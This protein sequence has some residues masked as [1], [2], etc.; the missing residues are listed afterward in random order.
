MAILYMRVGI[1]DESDP[2]VIKEL[3]ESAVPVKIDIYKREENKLGDKLKFLEVRGIYC[4]VLA[5][6]LDTS[7]EQEAKQ[8]ANKYNTEVTFIFNGVPWIVQPDPPAVRNEIRRES[9]TSSPSAK[10]FMS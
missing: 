4:H 3:I 5:G 10:T 6:S 2:K 7:V 8:L 9:L 1:P